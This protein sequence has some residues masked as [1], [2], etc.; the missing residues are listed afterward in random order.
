MIHTSHKQY[1]QDSLKLKYEN[2]FIFHLVGF[3][4]FQSN[5]LKIYV[6]AVDSVHSSPS[7]S[8]PFCGGPMTDFPNTSF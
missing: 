5:N 3:I 2:R 6:H 1:Y 7:F 4:S 8:S